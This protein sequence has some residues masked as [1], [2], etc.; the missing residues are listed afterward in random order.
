MRA[1]I[2]GVAGIVVLGLL[3][4]PA[5]CQ[6]TSLTFTEDGTIVSG[7]YDDVTI[8]STATV[9]MTGGIVGDMYIQNL[10][11]L[12]FE[13]GTIE[14]AELWSS[15][16]FNLEGASFD[17]TLSLNNSSIFNLNSGTFS[18]LIY[19]YEHSHSSI[20][21]GQ[22]LGID[23][24]MSSYAIADIYGGEVTIDFVHLHGDSVLN[25][26]GGDVTFTN[27]FS[28][29]EDGEI[30]VHYS[31]IIEWDEI[32]TG[33]HLLDGSEFMLD[34]FS[35]YEIDQINF[36]PEPATFLLLGLGGL[37]LRKKK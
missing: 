1:L 3:S 22:A 27:G 5:I 16:K 35:Q 24:E 11:T 25:V 17:N 18:G 15:A 6:A 29:Y 32:I 37:L 23:F 19:G 10:G 21:D 2:M 26:Y 14:G 8:M 28:L 34:Q 33:Y 31:D 13:G 4:V 9:G 30:N 12:N 20:N 7:A 36:V